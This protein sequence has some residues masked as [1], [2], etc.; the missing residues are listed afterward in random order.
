MIG[1]W[2]FALRGFDEPGVE[3]WGFSLR[4]T[5]APA[6]VSGPAVTRQA[7]LMLL[8]TSPGERVMRPTYGCPL[9]DLAFAHNND[10][11]AGI[12]MH[13]V[14][15]SV[16]EWVSEAEILQVDAGPDLDDPSV[17]RIRLDYRHRPTGESDVVEV[18][19]PLD[20]EL[21]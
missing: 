3:G 8:S 5:G 7:I 21:P 15:R 20:G 11:T 6:M 12:A 9:Q 17:L 1:G 4:P 16:E 19:V 10:T 13:Y 14:R 18:G 2:R